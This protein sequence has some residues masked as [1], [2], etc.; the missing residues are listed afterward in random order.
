[1]ISSSQLINFQDILH[2][3][4]YRKLD[5]PKYVGD[6]LTFLK[7]HYGANR[8]LRKEGY[9][10]FLEEIEEAEVIAWLPKEN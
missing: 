1:M 9:L 8:V 4:K 5:D 7:E 2:V 6:A 10:Y 3:L